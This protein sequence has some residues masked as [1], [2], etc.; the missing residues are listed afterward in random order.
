[1]VLSDRLGQVNQ[2]LNYYFEQS[3]KL[4]VYAYAQIKKDKSTHP[5]SRRSICGISGDVRGRCQDRQEIEDFLRN[6][7][8]NN[9]LK[10]YRRLFNLD[11][12]S[13]QAGVEETKQN[14][15]IGIVDFQEI[16]MVCLQQFS[17]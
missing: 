13:I 11:Y 3:L 6:D 8:V 15:K 17:F 4:F 12:V 10:K 5:Y 9:Y 2:D 14:V 7:L 16:K 1:M